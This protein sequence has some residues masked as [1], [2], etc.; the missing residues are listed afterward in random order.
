MEIGMG[1]DIERSQA[2]EAPLGFL[3]K[4]IKKGIYQIIKSI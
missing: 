4:K 1:A 3:K 2:S